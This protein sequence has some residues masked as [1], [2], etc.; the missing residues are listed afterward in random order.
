[1]NFTKDELFW[2]EC[3]ADVE[4]SMILN[5]MLEISKIEDN[6]T[7]IKLEHNYGMELMKS[8]LLLVELRN[9]L[10]AERNKA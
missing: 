9:K 6:D 7:R 8:Y 2:M 5:K 1:M 3:K 10:E 4:C